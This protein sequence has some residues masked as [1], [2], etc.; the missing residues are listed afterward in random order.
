MKPWDARYDE[1]LA[2]FDPDAMNTN[3]T[4]ETNVPLDVSSD[5]TESD[6]M[7]IGAE[8]VRTPRKVGGLDGAGWVAA[9]RK[10]PMR[11]TPPGAAMLIIEWYENRL[12]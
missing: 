10:D 12:P 9:V 3:D 7:K 4:K 8:S 2:Q 1:Q 6:A 11:T 5:R